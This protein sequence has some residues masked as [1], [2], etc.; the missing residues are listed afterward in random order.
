VIFAIMSDLL[1]QKT[2]DPSG[3]NKSLYVDPELLLIIEIEEK[4]MKKSGSKFNL[5]RFI[6]EAVLFFVK[7][8]GE[9]KDGY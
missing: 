7:Y 4:E 6:K 8:R 1:F 5:S 9:I 2:N 3:T